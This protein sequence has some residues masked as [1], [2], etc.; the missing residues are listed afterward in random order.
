MEPVLAL[1]S[2]AFLL[3]TKSMENGGRL[4]ALNRRRREKLKSILLQRFGVLSLSTIES[5]L[6]RTEDLFQRMN[7]DFEAVLAELS[8]EIEAAAQTAAVLQPKQNVDWPQLVQH[9]TEVQRLVA[10]NEQLS[11]RRKKE[12]YKEE[13]DR[14]MEEQ[15]LQREQ[16]LRQQKLEELTSA[17]T[18]EALHQKLA[19]LERQ[20]ISETRLEQKSLILESLQT[21]NARRDL[22][23]CAS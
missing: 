22:Q 21:R 4:A 11:A 17:A 18:V 12:Q 1:G 16:A 13:L 7:E 9:Q 15:R 3:R 8:H 10:I 6:S 19:A 2:R 20:S 14:L 5:A 23:V